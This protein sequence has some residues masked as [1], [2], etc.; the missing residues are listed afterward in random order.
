MFAAI[1]QELKIARARF[2][3]K[4]RKRAFKLV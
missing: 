1:E 2:Q 4:K 3:Q